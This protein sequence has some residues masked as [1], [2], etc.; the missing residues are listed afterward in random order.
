VEAMVVHRKNTGVTLTSEG[1]ILYDYARRIFKLVDEAREKIARVRENESGS[2]FISA[3]TIPSTYIL[4]YVLRVFNGN[5][6]EIRCYVQM[7]DSEATVNMVLDDQAEIGFVGKSVTSKKLNIDPV[8]NDRLVLIVPEGH[9]WQ[10]C[11]RIS[12]GELQK[13]PF[14]IR[15]RGSATRSVLEDCLRE[16]ADTGLSRFNIVSELGSSEAVKEAILAGLG[17][18]ILSIHAVKRELRDGTLVEVPVENYTIGR[19]FYLIYKKQFGLLRHH[20]LFIDFVR[21]SGTEFH[22]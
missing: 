7:N 3:S 8:W 1:K 18:S 5:Y 14:V 17:I 13:E 2:I 12:L 11:E 15:E 4:P 19:N 22:V 20:K 21:S 10:G 9:R 6:P 16:H